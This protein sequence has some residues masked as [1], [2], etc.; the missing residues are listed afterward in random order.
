MYHI[1]LLYI[2][3]ESMMTSFGLHLRYC[4]SVIP[5]FS[6]LVFWLQFSCR[7]VIDYQ[8]YYKRQYNYYCKINLPSVSLLKIFSTKRYPAKI[9]TAVPKPGRG[10]LHCSNNKGCFLHLS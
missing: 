7:M 5:C 3:L 2:E 1:I 4:I 9:T 6:N 10:L 8:K